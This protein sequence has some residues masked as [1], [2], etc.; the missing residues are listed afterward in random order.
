MPVN[1]ELHVAYKIANAQINT[2][3]Y[4]HI[5]VENV[6]PQDFYDEL[7][8]AI[9]EED[10]M[11]PIEE[12]RSVKGYKERFILEL[13]ENHLGR[14]PDTK[15]DFWMYVR[16]WLLGGQYGQLVINKFAPFLQERFKDKLD[17]IQFG[18]EALIV[19]DISRYSLGP[20]TDAKRKV[21][22]MLFYLPRDRSQMHLGTSVYLPKD[23]NFLCP[24]GPHYPHDD[25]HLMYTAP[26]APNSLFAFVK[27]DNSFHGVEPMTDPDCRRWLM[28]YDLNYTEKQT[29]PAAAA[30]VYAQASPKFSF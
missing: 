17:R 6:F 21:V 4:P 15:K 10:D 11:F 9:P 13:S 25:F 7:Q 19:E 18:D 20:H 22:T 16:T 14:L 30:P 26:F 1:P 2:F 8:K 3:P 12:V 28:L 23:P 24:G 5:Y 29:K 27:T